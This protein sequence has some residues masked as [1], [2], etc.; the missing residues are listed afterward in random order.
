MNLFKK[1][2]SYVVYISFAAFIIV[3]GLGLMLATKEQEIIYEILGGVFFGISIIALVI[4]FV[5]SPNVE[6]N[7]AKKVYKQNKEL[8][9]NVVKSCLKEENMEL[10]LTVVHDEQYVFKEGEQDIILPFDKDQDNQEDFIYFV[11]SIV[12]KKNFVSHSIKSLLS[13]AKNGYYRFKAPYQ[14]TK[15]V[16]LSIKSKNIKLN[17]YIMNATH[18]ED[19]NFDWRSSQEN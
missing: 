13:Y 9:V 10:L 4:L 17:K 7:K 2:L 3:V 18:E 8:F 15:I 6:Y 19:L 16:D 5:A 12:I 11:F 14:N 1:I